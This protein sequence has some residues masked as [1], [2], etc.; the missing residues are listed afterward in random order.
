MDKYGADAVF[1]RLARGPTK[2][3]ESVAPLSRNSLPSSSGGAVQ[4]QEG[5]QQQDL[6]ILDG[7][8]ANKLS[9]GWSFARKESDLGKTDGGR[10]SES[11]GLL[12][13]SMPAIF[14]ASAVF[15]DRFGTP[16][17]GAHI[18]PAVAAVSSNQG[19]RGQSSSGKKGSNTADK[20]SSGGAR[21]SCASAGSSFVQHSNPMF[22]F[23]A[24]PTNPTIH[25]SRQSGQAPDNPLYDSTPRISE[26]DLTAYATPRESD[27]GSGP[28]SYEAAATGSAGYVSQVPG[29]E[30]VTQQSAMMQT[31]P[32]KQNGAVTKEASHLSKLRAPSRLLLPSN[33]QAASISSSGVEHTQAR[34][35]SGNCIGLGIYHQQ[36]QQHG[37][38]EGAGV[39]ATAALQVRNL[40]IGPASLYEL[41]AVTA[42][43]CGTPTAV[44]TITVRRRSF[45]TQMTKLWDS[46]DD[47][48]CDGGSET[49]QNPRKNGW[50]RR[51]GLAFREAWRVYNADDDARDFYKQG[52][53]PSMDAAALFWFKKP[54]LVLKVRA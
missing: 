28:A 25:A 6:L 32:P 2:G 15:P 45:G 48:A 14:K 51:V 54:T 21:S 36:Q 43:E 39:R 38:K 27:D 53:D 52:M 7:Q 49:V 3:V 44:A 34:G 11:D 1:G 37:V 50:L 19:Q 30:A 4:Q 12:H 5:Q 31:F 42:G 40:Q 22:T 13:S 20:G 46:Q 35:A 17:V 33:K 8:Q 26:G 41:D 9:G 16:A 23:H 10:S 24:D 18:Y 29:H 47:G